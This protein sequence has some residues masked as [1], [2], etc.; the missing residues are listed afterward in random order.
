MLTKDDLNQIKLLLVSSDS[1]ILKKIDGVK[2]KMEEMDS[3]INFL[4]TK[5][6]YFDSMDK[7]MKEVKDMRD[8][9]ETIG[10]EY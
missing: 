5:E 9:Q 1:Q 8:S 4:P 3:K 10:R 7:L 6:E 2:E